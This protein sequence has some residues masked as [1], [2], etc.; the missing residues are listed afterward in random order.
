MQLKKEFCFYDALRREHDAQ[1]ISIALE[2]GLKI[3]SDQWS[4]LLY[5]DSAHKSHIQSI[6]D[7]VS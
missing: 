2:I 4:S 6:L 5:G 1:I 7:K 3:S